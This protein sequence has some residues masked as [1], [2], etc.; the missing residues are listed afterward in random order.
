[1]D[2]SVHNI[3]TS[4]VRMKLLF[5]STAKEEDGAADL[6]MDI[7]TELQQ[8]SFSP[9]VYLLQPKDDMSAIIR[10]CVS[11]GFEMLVVCG[12]DGTVSSVA[13]HLIGTN[14]TLGIIPTGT[15]NNIA[16]S[17]GIPN[18]IIGSIAVLKNG[19]RTKIDVGMATCDKKTMPFIEICSVGLFSALFPSGDDIQHG[20]LERIGDFLST[21]ADCPPSDIRLRLD[22]RQEIVKPGH[23]VIVS[24]MPYAGCHYQVG[25]ADSF[26]DGLLDV[27]FFSNVSKLDLMGYAIKGPRLSAE[28]DPRIEHFRVLKVEIDATPPMQVMADGSELGS[29]RVQI[30]LHRHMIFVMTSKQDPRAPTET[31]NIGQSGE[32]QPSEIRLPDIKV[33]ETFRRIMHWASCVQPIYW[34]ACLVV[35]LSI[36]MLILPSN[37]RYSFWSGLKAQGSIVTMLLAFCFISLSLVWST[38]QRIDVRLFMLFNMRGARPTWLDL[39]MFGFTQLGNGMV[40]MVLAFILFLSA[41]HILAYEIVLGSLSLWLIVELMKSLIRRGRPFIKLLQVR[42]VGFRAGGRSFPS[43]HTSQAFFMATLLS[44]FFH[45]GIVVTCL[46]YLTA[47]IIGIS[48]MYLGMHYPRDVLAGAIL[49]SV[50]SSVVV[51]IDIAIFH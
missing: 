49:G 23:V 40:T 47:L 36:F 30:H 2:K 37:V 44:Q 35:L 18:D 14:V 27:L 11:M 51:L 48:R 38:G 1:M 21:L 33:P 50:W 26:C 10:T 4:G 32:E 45:T 6:L 28:E 46:F 3:N 19:I 41:S 34:V 39:F 24:N 5:N 8:W 16:F 29:G 17:L 12:G 22:D 31:V 25:C 42:I 9:E 20:R 7:L 15:Q 43:G 13:K